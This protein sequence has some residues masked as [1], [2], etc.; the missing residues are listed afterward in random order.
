MLALSLSSQQKARAPLKRIP[1]GIHCLESLSFSRTTAF[2][3]EFSVRVITSLNPSANLIH[4]FNSSNELTNLELLN[5][6]PVD[7]RRKQNKIQKADYT[8]FQLLKTV[9]KTQAPIQIQ[10]LNH[11]QLSVALRG[12]LPF[13]FHSSCL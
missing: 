8:H 12:L 5:Q 10:L 11:I 1:K 9:R 6:Q 3:L 4:M 13:S 2:P 7:F